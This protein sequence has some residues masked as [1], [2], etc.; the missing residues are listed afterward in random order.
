MELEFNN[1]GNY[2]NLFTGN[3]IPYS[4]TNTCNTFRFS[5][6]AAF[7]AA[8]TLSATATQICNKIV[9]TSENPGSWADVRLNIAAGLAPSNPLSY[10][11]TVWLPYKRVFL[12]VGSNNRMSETTTISQGQG[13]SWGI[14]VVER[15]KISQAVQKIR[16]S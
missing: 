15:D 10:S 9:A 2:S 16:S 13:G 8:T 12:C 11:I 1:S 4:T 5:N 7:T 3:Y 14:P 6:A